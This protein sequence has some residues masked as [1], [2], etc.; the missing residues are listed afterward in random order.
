MGKTNY[1]IAVIKEGKVVNLHWSE[2][3]KDFRTIKILNP[4]CTFE[5]IRPAKNVVEKTIHLKPYSRNRKNPNMVRCIDTGEIY[6]SIRECSKKT[7]IPQVGI[8]QSI[9]KGCYARGVRFEY[10]CSDK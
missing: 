1:L 10:Y 5:V 4:N 8:Y 2:A 3:L 9:R 7:G 6:S